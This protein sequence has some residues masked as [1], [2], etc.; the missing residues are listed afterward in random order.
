MQDLRA[1]VTENGRTVYAPVPSSDAISFRLNHFKRNSK[2]FYQVDATLYLCPQPEDA[3]RLAPSLARRAT[4]TDG[5]CQAV[6]VTQ[7]GIFVVV[8]GDI[9]NS[10]VT[11]GDVTV[12]I[13]NED[14]GFF[15]AVA[16]RVQG[17]MGTTWG[18]LGTISAGS[19]G[20][21]LLCACTC[22]VCARLRKGRPR[23]NKTS[24]DI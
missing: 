9:M 5:Q 16:G 3:R 20:T 18:M 17:W 2:L 23:N 13:I 22:F 8:S 12:V 11:G 19:L 1:P 6:T 24:D 15:T 14:G 10:N 4:T 7:R 21:V